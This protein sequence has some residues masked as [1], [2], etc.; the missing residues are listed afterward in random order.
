MPETIRQEVQRQQEALSKKEKLEPH[1]R[2]VKPDFSSKFLRPMPGAARM[3][4]ETDLPLIEISDRKKYEI[5]K[6]LPELP[7]KKIRRLVRAG[8]NEELAEQ[9]M[10]SR[11]FA[12]LHKKFPKTDAKLIATTLISTQ[13]EVK[14]KAGQDFG[15]FEL[16]H[17]KQ[18]FK[19]LEDGKIAK[20]AVPEI[21]LKVAEG[22]NVSEAAN[23][24]KL[25]SDSEIKKEIANLKKK[26][27]KVPADKL[28]GII[29]GKLRGRADVQKVLRFLN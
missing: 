11:K 22:E 16:E 1:V 20:E 4:P 2:N 13:K 21:L 15:A 12:E 19:L 14:K 25:L 10:F 28:K 9:V 6:N 5:R 3:Y 18:I 26:F 23:R 27:A 29:V 17:Y 7:E 8:L 24:F